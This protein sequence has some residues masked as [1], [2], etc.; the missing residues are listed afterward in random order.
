MGDV[1]H[2]PAIG[3][4]GGHRSE[5]SHVADRVAVM[6]R[7]RIV[8]T[9]PVEQILGNPQHPYTRALLDCVPRLHE[10]RARLQT[11]DH[12]ALEA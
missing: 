9:G 8:E 3:M 1:G 6:F 4:E 5:L 11:I 7:G 2:S 12:A 10:R